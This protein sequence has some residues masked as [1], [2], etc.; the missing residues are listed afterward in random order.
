MRINEL[1]R[2]LEVKAK[3]IL[4]YLAESGIED[5]KS[6]SSAI[7]DEL[8]EKVK[9]HF[10][11]VAEAPVPE[12]SELAPVAPPPEKIS[13]GDLEP[14]SPAPVRPAAEAEAKAA[15]S[16]LSATPAA[17]VPVPAA[18]RKAAPGEAP[19][20]PKRAFVLRPPVRSHGEPQVA[21][22]PPGRPMGGSP[23]GIP[24]TTSASSG[25][26]SIST[27]APSARATR[28]GTS[29]SPSPSCRTCPMPWTSS[30]NRPSRRTSTGRRGRSRE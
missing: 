23:S 8:G 24:S 6:H 9:A 17:T 14:A 1:A 10:R 26:A 21:P 19:A 30:S 15:P 4:D 12:P 5:K 29:R 7:D 18:A 2:E 25:G 27:T 22:P 11:Q 13:A 16:R 20:P 28:S 3:A